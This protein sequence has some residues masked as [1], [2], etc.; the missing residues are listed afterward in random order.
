[1]QNSEWREKYMMVN[2]IYD[3]ILLVCHLGE[4]N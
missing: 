3:I 1:M 4:W 2:E